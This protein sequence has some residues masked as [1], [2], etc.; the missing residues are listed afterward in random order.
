MSSLHDMG[1]PLINWRGEKVML[2]VQEMVLMRTF[3]SNRV[4]KWAL[5][6]VWLFICLFFLKRK[7]PK[8]KQSAFVCV[9]AFSLVFFSR[10]GFSLPAS[11]CN[12][13]GS[14]AQTAKCDTRLSSAMCCQAIRAEIINTW[15]W[16]PSILLNAIGKSSNEK[17]SALYR[18]PGCAHNEHLER[19]RLPGSILE[20]NSSVFTI[21]LLLWIPSW[22][23]QWRKCLLHYLSSFF[24]L[25]AATPPTVPVIHEQSL[26]RTDNASIIINL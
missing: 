16:S 8:H 12:S 10:W 4:L 22:F 15:K 23:L 24:C 25:G 2:L 13:A 20:Y 5:L 14:V 7:Q 26:E 21:E 19:R 18:F 3:N 1:L 11:F 17:I 6:H 9:C